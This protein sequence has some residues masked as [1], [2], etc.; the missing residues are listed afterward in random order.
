MATYFFQLGSHEPLAHEELLA[1]FAARSQSLESLHVVGG[2]AIAQ[3]KSPLSIAS[4]Q[5]LLGGTI[6]AG[7]II[8]ET[9]SDVSAIAEIIVPRLSAGKNNIGVSIFGSASQDIHES[10]AMDLKRELTSRG[11]SIRIITGDAGVLS[12]AQIHHNKLVDDGLDLSLVFAGDAVHVGLSKSVQD[13]ESW[14]ERDYGRP[15]RDAHSGMLPPK[16]ARMMLNI[17]GVQDTTSVL[18]PFCGSGTV[19]SEALTMGVR[20]VYGS[21]I[22]AKA[23]ADSKKNTAWADATAKPIIFQHDARRTFPITGAD[24]VVAETYLGPARLPNS[25][26]AVRTIQKEIQALLHEAVVALGAMKQAPKTIVLAIPMFWSGTEWFRISE[27]WIKGT[28]YKKAA[29]RV[30]TDLF[31]ARPTAAVGRE[32]VRLSR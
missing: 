21:D 1:V 3:C 20:T 29:P 7:E 6:K 22:S 31:Y 19:L 4:L 25:E 27:E 12:S 26:S 2:V 32:I 24:A 8:G 16:L 13:F 9:S 30:G 17:A 18:D 28:Q 15:A 11:F 14:S 23:V 10:L 5:S